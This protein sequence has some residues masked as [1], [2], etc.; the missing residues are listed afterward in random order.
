MSSLREAPL[1][2]G[3][4]QARIS[5]GRLRRYDGPRAGRA[6]AVLAL[7]RWSATGALGARRGWR[8]KL[9]P[10]ALSLIALTPAIVV[11][12]VRALVPGDAIELDDITFSGYQRLTSAVILIFAGLVASE[13]VCPDRRDGVLSLYFSTAVSRLEYVVAK[14]IAVAVPMLL[15]T[16]VP[17]AFLYIGIVVFEDAPVTYLREN[18][19]TVGRIGLSGLLVA[20]YFA[21][22]GVAVASLTTRRAYAV[23]AYLALLVG[24]SVA[25]GALLEAGGPAWVDGF[26]LSIIPAELGAR[27]YPGAES[28]SDLSAV[29]WL[30]AYAIVLAVASGML[31]W[32]FRGAD[33]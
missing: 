25:A 16:L 30:V 33:L 14:I 11:L 24:S 15:V 2:A 1:E 19:L 18:W 7:A 3:R 31:R 8:A 20:G 17:M 29:G 4:G 32:R 5:D 9:V 21:I 28:P 23:G 22:V 6:A 27:L 13:A 10:T 26:S 12:G